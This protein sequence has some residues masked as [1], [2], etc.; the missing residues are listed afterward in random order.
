M[1]VPRVLLA[2]VLPTTGPAAAESLQPE[3]ARSF[4][5]GK[6]FSFNCVE[7]SR[8]M[9][10]IFSDGSV[11]GDIQFRGAP[12][13][14][15]VRLPAGTLQVR[16]QTYCATIPGVPLEPCFDVDRMGAR[17]FRG[18]LIGLRSASCE[19][20]Q[21]ADDPVDRGVPRTRRSMPVQLQPPVVTARQ[22]D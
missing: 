20:I 10:R 1:A 7:G 21:R 16:G 19:F 8:G 11:E 12:E 14:R 18:S 13:M 15:H 6:L 22:T 4:I 5:A 17:A 2:V 3:T 9:G